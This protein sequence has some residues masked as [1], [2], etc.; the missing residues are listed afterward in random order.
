M[1][2]RL[3]RSSCRHCTSRQTASSSRRR[4]NRGSSYRLRQHAELMQSMCAPKSSL[5]AGSIHSTSKA[6]RTAAEKSSVLPGIHVGIRG[7]F[8][9]ALLGKNLRGIDNLFPLPVEA[10]WFGR[11][12]LT[13][14]MQRSRLLTNKE[15]L[16]CR[17][18]SSAL[19]TL[20][21]TIIPG[22]PRRST[23]VARQHDGS[24]DRRVRD[25]PAFAR[26]RQGRYTRTPGGRRTDWRTKSTDHRALAFASTRI[27]APPHV[28]APSVYERKISPQRYS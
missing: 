14:V 19:R 1:G 5:P 6:A 4:A 18:F 27:G 24:G 26:R 28:A 10:A 3:R 2:R 22:L 7:N 8:Y 13:S 9:S 20:S 16:S 21:E 11:C 15:T 12:D 25:T 17:P 23:V